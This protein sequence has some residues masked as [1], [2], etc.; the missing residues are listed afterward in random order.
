V[1]LSKPLFAHTS[2]F[3]SPSESIRKSCHWRGRWYD[4]LS[5]WDQTC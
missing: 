3:E 4:C 1:S 2:L 5:N